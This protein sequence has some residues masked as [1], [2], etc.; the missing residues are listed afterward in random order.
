MTISRRRVLAIF[1]KELREYRHNGNIIYAMAIVPL[2]IIIQPAIVVFAAPAR[3]AAYLA[4]GH[5]LLFLLGIPAIVPALV[6]AYSVVG[7]R[8]QGTLEPVL[9]T[10]V[11]REE[12]LLAKA[13]A[14]FL[15]SVAIAYGIYAAFV[16]CIELFAHP[17][18]ASALLQTPEILAQV[19]F[20]PLIT[21]WS[22]W[23]SIGISARSNDVRVAQQLS[24]LA[25]L[26][27]FA[28][29]A[30]IAYDVIPFTLRLAL[31]LGAALLILDGLGWRISSATFNRERL[32]S[33][34]RL[35]GWGGAWPGNPRCGAMPW[36]RAP[37]DGTW[38][39]CGCGRRGPLPPRRGFRRSGCSGRLVPPAPPGRGVCKGRCRRSGTGSGR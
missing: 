10:P 14:S 29:T 27:A 39:P 21:A 31:G 30:L 9:T 2:V 6:A 32:I 22:V 8:E 5:L 20:T 23:V 34:A 16:A 24:A 3:A 33:G 28:V 18:V 7:E 13:L 17:A 19:A 36:R 12:F 35:P 1:R 26:P 38:A 37:V 4:Q 15:P 25:S 11:R